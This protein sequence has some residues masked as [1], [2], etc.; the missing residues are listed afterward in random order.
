MSLA[1]YLADPSGYISAVPSRS[2]LP[3][4]EAR[5]ADSPSY[6][7]SRRAGSSGG[8][9]GMGPGEIA[10]VVIGSVAGAGILAALAYFV[11]YKRLYQVH[12]ATSFKRSDIPEG[13]AMDGVGAYPAAAYGGSTANVPVSSGPA[14]PI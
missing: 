9:G 10:G 6:A 13:P 2:E 8:S 12:D 1:E 5:P 4:P 11:G 7:A 3:A 14:R